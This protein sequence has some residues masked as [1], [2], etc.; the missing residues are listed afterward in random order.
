MHGAPAGSIAQWTR[1]EKRLSACGLSNFSIPSTFS[2]AFAG[3][4]LGGRFRSLA[5]SVLDTVIA[6][7]PAR[8]ATSPLPM[9]SASVLIIAPSLPRRL[10][11]VVSVVNCNS[12]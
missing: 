9:S 3:A 6:A 2:A 12:T 10:S 11:P 7:V 1:F 5:S 8:P 4:V